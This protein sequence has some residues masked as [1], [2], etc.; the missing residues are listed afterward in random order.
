MAQAIG[1]KTAKRLT[2]WPRDPRLLPP[3]LFLVTGLILFSKNARLGM[4]QIARTLGIF[5]SVLLG[6]TGAVGC[7][8]ASS[9]SEPVVEI[10]RTV[11][12]M[13]TFDHW[14]HVAAIRDYQLRPLTPPPRW[15]IPDPPKYT[16]CVAHL[17]Q[18]AHL[19]TAPKPAPTVSQLKR[20]CERQQEQLRQQVLGSLITG[21]W[22]IEEGRNRGIV[23]TDSEIK[24]R[25]ELSWKNNFTSKS[26]LDTYLANTGETI[27]DQL[28]RAK[29][30][31]Y[32]TRLEEQYGVRAGGGSTAQQR[33][34]GE[35]ISALP[36][37][38][39]PKTTCRAGYVI[40]DCR[41][42]KGPT[43]PTTQLL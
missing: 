34:F 6:A 10:G 21:W 36:R 14:M 33:A 9:A 5:G 32:S 35:F 29:I 43:P 27:A 3:L 38:W 37:K 16:V 4:T 11:I 13:S 12:T 31:V 40:P 17:E 23:A 41:Q 7:G 28:F 15:A 2:A 18:T 26:E 25:F 8:G 24:R 22:Y 42:Y 19:P 20:Q 1:D 39:A 30:K